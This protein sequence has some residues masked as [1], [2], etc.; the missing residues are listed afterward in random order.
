MYKLVTGI[1]FSLVSLPVVAGCTIESGSTRAALLELYTSEGC[2]SCPPAD[3]WLSR[4]SPS[5]QKLVPLALHVDYWDYIGWRDVFA[6]PVFSDRQRAAAGPGFVYTPQVM[7]NGQDFRGWHNSGRMEEALASINKSI[8]QAGIRM[9]VVS[10]E[11]TL[12]IA[13]E[14]QSSVPADVYVAVFENNL[15]SQVRAGENN[16]TTL[17]HDYVVR[18]WLGPFTAGSVDVLRHKA[19]LQSGWKRK[20]LGVAAFVQSKKSGEVLQAVAGKACQ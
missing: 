4:L 5:P 2:S 15:V 8:P 19:T 17:H 11:S 13:V 7:L 6:K 12:D 10:A 3:R 14:T 9:S 16:G 18:E 20:D 1:I